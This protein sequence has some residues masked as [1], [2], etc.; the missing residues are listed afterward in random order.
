MSKMNLAQFQALVDG[1]QNALELVKIS[2][3]HY[4]RKTL[5]SFEM[6]GNFDF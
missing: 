3:L 1:M 2:L 4:Q 5:I 6:L